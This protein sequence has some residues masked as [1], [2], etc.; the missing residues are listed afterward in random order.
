LVFNDRNYGFTGGVN[1]GI[2][3][4]FENNCDAVALFNNDAVADRDWLA[5]LN[6]K[7]TV[8]TGIVT[9]LLLHSDGKTIDSTGDYYSIWGLPFPRG[10]NQPT[11]QA[12]KSGS[13][14]GASGGASLYSC[15]MLHEIGVFDDNFFAYYEDVDVSFRAQLAGWKVIYTDK[16]VAYHEQGA[17]SRKMPGLAVYQTFKNLPLLFIKNVPG[18]LLWPIGMRFY[19]AYFVMLGHAIVSG[20]LAPAVKGYLAHLWYFW[21]AA[22]WQRWHVQHDIKKVNTDYIHDIIWRDLPPDQTGLRKLRGIF[23]KKK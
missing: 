11:D 15:N 1:A 4:A 6:K 19:F 7:L 16:A 5:N 10:R 17:T 22:I 12:P 8:K 18:R 13:V 20:N 14:F 3:W 23:I 9:G 21:T 2:R